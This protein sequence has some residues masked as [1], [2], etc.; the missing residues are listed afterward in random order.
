MKDDVV[1]L[2]FSGVFTNEVNY[3][4]YAGTNMTIGGEFMKMR[5][6]QIEGYYRESIDN[7][8]EDVLILMFA[9]VFRNEVNYE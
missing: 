9:V 8:K 4:Q 6:N 1:I 2:M 7:Y 5:F 3:E